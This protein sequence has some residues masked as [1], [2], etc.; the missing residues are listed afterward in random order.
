LS[1]RH[2]VSSRKEAADG[3]RAPLVQPRGYE[4]GKLAACDTSSGAT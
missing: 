4:N 1:R 2:I 3:E